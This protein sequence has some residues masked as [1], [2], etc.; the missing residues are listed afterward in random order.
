MGVGVAWSSSSLGVTVGAGLVGVGV[1][2][3][4]ES[5]VGVLGVDDGIE[6]SVLGV[7]AVVTEGLTHTRSDFYRLTLVNLSSLRPVKSDDPSSTQG[8]SYVH[9][10]SDI[11][12]DN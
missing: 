12:F 10:C 4:A 8:Q 5:F 9:M 7:G 2:T 11:V 1:E 6:L 3:G